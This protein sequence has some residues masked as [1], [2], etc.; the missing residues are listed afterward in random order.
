MYSAVERNR[1]IRLTG[2]A[3]V[4][5]PDDYYLAV[6]NDGEYLKHV[7]LERPPHWVRWTQSSQPSLFVSGAGEPGLLLSDVA[8]LHVGSL[9]SV[10]QSTWL[11]PFLRRVI[12]SSHG[13][14]DSG[15]SEP[16]VIELGHQMTLYVRDRR[17]RDLAESS[18]RTAATWQ[19][20]S[21]RD[22]A[23]SA[24][25]MGTK[26]QLVP[27]IMAALDMWCPETETLVDLMTG[28]GIVAGAFSRKRPTWASDA[29]NFSLHLACSQGGGFSRAQAASLLT[30]LR[31]R[32]EKYRS[33]LAERVGEA[34]STEESI[35]G[36]TSDFRELATAYAGLVQRFPTFPDGGTFGR[37]NPLAEVELCRVNPGRP[38][39]LITAYYANVFFGI[40]QAVDLDSIRQALFEVED[41][42]LRAFAVGAL[43]VTAS[44]VATSYGGH[45]A[46][47]YAPAAR[48]AKPIVLKRA[49]EYRMRSV[50][51]EFEVRLLALGSESEAAAEPVR[52]VAG[53]WDDA[54]A[55]LDG[56]G[57]LRDAT[58]YVDPPY[59]RDEY[60]RYYHVLE[61][62]V[63]YDYPE[64][65]GGGKVP[66]KGT[67]RFSSEFHT[68]SPAK[69]VE[70]LQRVLAGV[71]STGAT[72]IWSHSTALDVP[73]EA[74][75][76]GL[77]VSECASVAAMHSFKKQGRAPQSPSDHQEVLVL[78]R[79]S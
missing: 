54:V 46:Q 26:R 28:S 13:T 31:P 57:V 3:A 77:S 4:S 6:D 8:F 65:A 12:Q 29:Q 21:E 23:N 79:P 69:R 18:L 33:S 72:C 30:D 61:T 55:A 17:I 34:L 41:P 11:G 51:A 76:R 62:L 44:V 14:S 78:L 38:G 40:R 15:D 53:P 59:T 35:F 10:P 5:S 20:Y 74:V 19:E 75:I 42:R 64:V 45:F 70:R 71:L 24:H 52:T 48:L 36:Q 39:C 47:P 37:W 67:S 25:Y 49:L 50:L 27:L 68:R 58:V 73:L 60:S 2:L 63:R 16:V 22:F 43:V 66:A 1:Y 7:R 56:Q 9:D 32:I